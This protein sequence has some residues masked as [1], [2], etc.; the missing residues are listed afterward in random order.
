ME[1]SLT[2]LRQLIKEEIVQLTEL[3]EPHELSRQR[4]LI[5]SI[6]PS[7]VSLWDQ[8]AKDLKLKSMIGF[9]KNGVAVDVVYKGRGPR[10]VVTKRAQVLANKLKK[11]V[12]RVSSSEKPVDDDQVYKLLTF[13]FTMTV[14]SDDIEYINYQLMK[15]AVRMTDRAGS[16]GNIDAGVGQDD[17]KRYGLTARQLATWL[18]AHGASPMKK[19]KHTVTPSIYD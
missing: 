10:G 14:T 16:M 13:A 6:K 15:N 12:G 1:I 4:A 9:D 8:A 19:R 5:A 17:L 18:A 2:Q 7:D 11:A 3:V